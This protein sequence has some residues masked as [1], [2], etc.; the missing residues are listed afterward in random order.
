MNALTANAVMVFNVFGL[1]WAGIKARI[2]L[3]TLPLDH[4]AGV[5]RQKATYEL[6]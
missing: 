1:I 6:M 4:Y 2:K 5:M 3:G